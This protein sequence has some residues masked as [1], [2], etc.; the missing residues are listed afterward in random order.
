MVS[1]QGG[2][3]CS[4]QLGNFYTLGP[5]KV[6]KSLMLEPNPGQPRLF[7]LK[8]CVLCNSH[9]FVASVPGRAPPG[10]CYSPSPA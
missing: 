9:H 2:P 6:N 4:S 3:G 1:V 7:L 5:Y 10:H 8:Q